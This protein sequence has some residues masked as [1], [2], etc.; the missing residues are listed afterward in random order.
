M[1]KN[2]SRLHKKKINQA[3]GLAIGSVVVPVSFAFGD[4]LSTE[5]QTYS[6]NSPT[7]L[8]VTA[9]DITLNNNSTVLDL[10]IDGNADNFV[11]NND[12]NKAVENDSLDT[13]IRFD[14]DLDGSVN[15]DGLIS[16][17]VYDSDYSAAILV[18]DRISGDIIN[19]TDTDGPNGG[20]VSYLFSNSYSL[21][22][23][24]IEADELTGTIDN[25]GLILGEADAYGESEQTSAAGI[26]LNDAGPTASIINNEY[27]FESNDGGGF[28]VG[29]S[30]ADYGWYS[31]AYGII[32]SDFIGQGEFAGELVNDGVV[33]GEAYYGSYTEAYGVKIDDLTGTLINSETGLIYGVAAQADDTANAVGVGFDRITQAGSVSNSGTILGYSYNEFGNSFGTGLL[34]HDTVTGDITNNGL[35]AGLSVSDDEDSYS[36]SKAYG[37]D[38]SSLQGTLTNSPNDD[39]DSL[40]TGLITGEAFAYSSNDTTVYDGSFR[41]ESYA[42]GYGVD[43]SEVDTTGAVINDSIILGEAT[44]EANLSYLETNSDH[45][46]AVDEDTYYQSQAGTDSTGFSGSDLTGSLDNSGLIM[47]EA[48]SDSDASYDQDLTTTQNTNSVSSTTV[49]L[50]VYA[51][52]DSESY[53]NA[54]GINLSG[55]SVNI[56]N[57]NGWIIGLADAYST[58]DLD[59]SLTA[60]TDNTYNVESVTQNNYAD[61]DGSGYANAYSN[62]MAHG[63]FLDDDTGAG[64]L[65]TNGVDGVIGASAEAYSYAESIVTVS[66]T[67][68]GTAT[69][70]DYEQVQSIAYAGAY[71][72]HYD[73]D[74]A[75]VLSNSGVIVATALADAFYDNTLQLDSRNSYAE[76]YAYGVKVDYDL[77]GILN[78]E[79]SGQ[80]YASANADDQDNDDYAWAYGVYVDDEL[81]GQINNAGLISVYA[82]ADNE[83]IAKGIYVDQE[84]EGSIYSSGTIE[85]ESDGLYYSKAVGISGESLAGSIQ[86]TDTGEIYASATSSDRSVATGIEINWDMESGSEILNDGYISST[87]ETYM[88]NQSTDVSTYGIF[89]NGEA[90]DTRGQITNNGLIESS[91]TLVW[92]GEESGG[93]YAESYGILIDGEL[94]LGG[95]V[96]NNGEIIATAY[97]QYDI[98]SAY[99]YGIA[100]NEFDE[101]ASLINRGTIRAL[102]GENRDTYDGSDGYSVHILYGDGTLDNYGNLFGSLYLGEEYAGEISL[103]NS[104]MAGIIHDGFGL[105][106]ENYT[107]RTRGLIGLGVNSES[108]HA[109]FEVDGIADFTDSNAIAM[110]V[111][112]D[113]TLLD[114]DVLDDALYM[115]SGLTGAS[116]FR[117]IDN[118]L[119]LN[120]EAVEAS[121]GSDDVWDINVVATGL[122]TINAAQTFM[123]N[124][125]GLDAG[126]ILQDGMDFTNDAFHALDTSW[127]P[128]HRALF[129]LGSLSTEAEVSDAV[130]RTLPALSGATNQVGL[131]VTRTMTGMLSNR[132]LST[133]GMSSGNGYITNGNLWVKP[134]GGFAD[135]NSNKGVSGY[136]GNF[137]GI[138]SGID[139]GVGDNGRMGVGV[140]Y[141][142]SSMDSDGAANQNAVSKN[143]FASVYGSYMLT[144][145]L[146]LNVQAGY[147]KINNE[148]NRQVNFA[149]INYRA[150]SDY[151]GDVATAGVGLSHL[152][153]ASDTVSWVTSLRTDYALI[154]TDSYTEKGQDALSLNALNLDVGGYKTEELIVS[155]KE[156]FQYKFTDSAMAFA[157]IGVGHDAINDKAKMNANF[158][159]GSFVNIGNY[160]VDPIDRSSTIYTGALGVDV[161]TMSG[162]TVTGRYDF[163]GRSDYTN[164]VG[165]LRIVLPF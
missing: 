58:A 152:F 97:D 96:E 48:S 120:F 71:G 15:N 132:L 47:G 72:V 115:N 19:G 92:D 119:A 37:I 142:R 110:N 103:D 59:M 55:D 158:V 38:A 145:A 80:I 111:G 75:G 74:M 143:V 13:A 135:Q 106:S 105:V 23:V 60:T 7:A 52:M 155:L 17:D 73:Q 32:V 69:A 35:I 159:G 137:A 5:G 124:Q 67:A 65:I 64:T 89:V 150:R 16:S 40:F 9:D 29:T 122:T 27:D 139:W 1:D 94:T 3:V 95:A 148:N 128:M 50:D 160:R 84:I 68:D 129:E 78:N 26:I 147:G 57:N 123:G 131:D 91:A 85:A 45:G 70:D 156:E 144:G 107:Q 36:Y 82:E 102:A 108:D 42:K 54:Y 39:S 62:A 146:Q 153:K 49:M 2:I 34:V 138:A 125:S 98:N 28:I 56:I 90:G 51:S 63:I 44:S 133:S 22:S 41:Q 79:S 118:N 136:D 154:D 8:E 14:D 130:E 24:G 83:S 140:A 141:A 11:L 87:A 86:I 21:V 81:L 4:V 104:G 31:A 61:V 113:N 161:L 93:T 6:N 76:A 20:I 30:Y 77:T 100:I 18:D 126:R 12:E 101:S 149:G 99:A 10:Q 114:G 164:H 121:P 33:L 162:W 43:I 151:D 117:M 88:L 112:A 157:S 165:S 163:T 25:S 109:T 66:A 134:F 53:A 46:N 127:S 116:D